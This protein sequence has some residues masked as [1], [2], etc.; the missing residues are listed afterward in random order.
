MVVYT[1]ASSV[2]FV[3]FVIG[4]AWYGAI[5]LLAERIVLL[6]SPAIFAACS[7]NTLFTKTLSEAPVEPYTPKKPIANTNLPQE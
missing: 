6:Q 4:C 1:H 3:K 2:H 7:R 5:Y